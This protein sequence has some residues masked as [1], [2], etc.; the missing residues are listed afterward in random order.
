M[1]IPGVGYEAASGGP[2]FRGEIHPSL[3]FGYELTPAFL[4]QISTIKVVIS[5]SFTGT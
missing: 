5:K 4:V 2:F 3:H 1:I